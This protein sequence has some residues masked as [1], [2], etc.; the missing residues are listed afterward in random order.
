MRVEDV[1]YALV[2]GQPAAYAEQHDGHDQAPEVELLAMSEVVIL[3]GRLVRLTDADQQQE[4]VAGV[5]HRVDAF[6]QH[7]R[8]TGD[9]GRH[10]LGQRYTEVRRGCA[11]YRDGPARPVPLCHRRQPPISRRTSPTSAIASGVP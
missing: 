1:L 3:V 5:H 6:R 7:G 8:A 10:E 4:L 9:G 11:V 2:E